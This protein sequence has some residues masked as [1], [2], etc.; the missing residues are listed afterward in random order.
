[1]ISTATI[2]VI[3][4]TSIFV[5]VIAIIFILRARPLLC[6]DLSIC[7]C[8]SLCR[9]HQVSSSC[10]P[11]NDRYRRRK[12]RD[13]K[14]EA[15]QR[16]DAGEVLRKLRGLRASQNYTYACEYTATHAIDESEGTIVGEELDY[17][18]EHGANAWEFVPGP[19]NRGVVV[20]NGTEIEFSG[21]EQSLVTNLQFPNEQRV[22]YFETRLDELP[23]DT[24]VAV[25][26]AMKDYPPLRMAGWARN[27]VAYHTINGN[28]YY[29]HP[30]DRCRK[31][32]R[33]QT[34]DTIGIG[35][36][37]RSGKVFVAINGAIVC[38]I[39]TPWIQKRLYP[40]VSADGPCKLSV[41]VG[42][43]AFVLSHAN[44]R[45]WGL[46]PPEGARP[47][48]PMYQHA[49][50]SMLLD[51]AANQE[52]AG[53]S[54]STLIAR[55]P[56][57]GDDRQANYTRWSRAKDWANYT[58]DIS[59]IMALDPEADESRGPG[60]AWHARSESSIYTA[61][62]DRPNTLGLQMAYRSSSATS[63]RS[64]SRSGSA[65]PAS[66][67]L[68]LTGSDLQSTQRLLAAPSLAQAQTSSSAS[69][70]GTGVPVFRA[71]SSSAPAPPGH[72]PSIAA[73]NMPKRS[74][75]GFDSFSSDHT[76]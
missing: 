72:V 55:P 18:I 36:R 17:V 5:L 54:L 12:A 37:P 44:M 27:S 65:V 69:V 7:E 51:S 40:V 24:N 76:S 45:Y 16:L 32:I 15:I 13:R 50:D 14:R 2:A 20:S 21:G 8:G 75:S 19:E 29:S 6:S 47:P 68:E 57:Y 66:D 28:A 42:A 4:A 3:T 71:R 38:H 73:Q 53:D 25:G 48:P 70:S 41:N 34:S 10:L 74:P 31:C 43:R 62:D 56:S 33:A 1:M 60:H 30:L 46:A 22:Y 52:C 49:S 9:G 26:I 61:E 63:S 35:W 67:I 64:R 11:E 58:D 23:S 39:R 59:V